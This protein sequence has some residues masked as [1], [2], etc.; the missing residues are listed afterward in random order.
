MLTDFVTLPLLNGG[1]LSVN[2]AQVATVQRAGCP[3]TPRCVLTLA[4]GFDCDIA[5]SQGDTVELLTAVPD[6]FRPVTLEEL[7]QVSRD[8]LREALNERVKADLA[9]REVS[10]AVK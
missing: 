7:Q 8:K 2:P 1:V 3:D 6:F 10:E 5:L 4:S 9:A